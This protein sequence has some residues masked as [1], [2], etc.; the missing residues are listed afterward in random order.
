MYHPESNLGH[1]QITRHSACAYIAEYH[2][3]ILLG[4]TGS[5]KTYLDCALE[6]ASVRNFLTV[7]YVRLPELL[8]DLSIARDNG[9]F[10]KTMAQYKKYYPGRM[11]AFPAQRDRSQRSTR[12]H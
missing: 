11:A 6:M 12:N 1:S 10:C 5:G 3:V 8:V 2:I 7:K 4:A 9:T